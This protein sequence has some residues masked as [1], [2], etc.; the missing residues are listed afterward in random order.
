[1]QQGQDG[2]PVQQW[3]A[4][5]LAPQWQV[6]T[7]ANQNLTAEQRGGSGS[8]AAAQANRTERFGPTSQNTETRLLAPEIDWNYAAIE[9]LDPETLKTTLIPF[10]LGK[11]VLEHD[12][13]QDLEMRAGD[14]LSIFSEADIRVPIA[15][16]TKLIKLEGEFVHAGSY[17]AQPGETLRHL[18]ERAGGFTPNAYLY[19]SEF[20]RESTR[21]IQQARIDEYV[22]SL[23]MGIQRS[24]L[25]LSA[26]AA[27]SPQDIASGTAAQSSE[28]ELLARLRQIRATGR[29]VLEFKEDSR[30]TTG[31]PEITMEDGDSFVVPSAPASINV[32]GAVYDQN[33]FLH[34]PGRNVGQY[35]HL[36]G[37]PNRNA[38]RRHEFIIRADG[39]V[40]SRDGENGPWGNRF[41]KLK[42]YP[43]DTVVVPDK[44]FKPSA[45]RGIL[46]WSQ[47]F[48]QLALGSAAVSVLR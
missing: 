6:G 29:I 27:S 3:Q 9:R 14:V 5:A 47:I 46:D 24:N 35:L 31:L 39:E 32:V 12:G 26:S 11:L 44:T 36:A 10:D 8:L 4:G 17:T 19:G 13:S 28:R 37:G 15:Q 40:I 42:L 20:A 48:S 7:R 30:G 38:D 23:D 25:A 22:R 41:D 43:G 21:A 2:T 1:M 45:L 34:H 16:Q 33:S 18:V